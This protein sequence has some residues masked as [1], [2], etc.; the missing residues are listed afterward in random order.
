[1]T[2]ISIISACN[3]NC[4]YCF[5]Q[6]TYHKANLMLTYEEILDIFDWVADN[7][8]MGILGGEP[9]LHPDIVKILAASCRMFQE[10]ILMTNLICD[11]SIIKDIV[12]YTPTCRMLINTTTRD[13]LVDIFEENI[14]YLS[15]NLDSENDV[16]LGTTFINDEEYDLKSI[17]RLIGLG[18]KYP[19][20]KK[21]YRI[22]VATPY[23]KGKI[24]LE[25]FEKPIME[26]CARAKAETPDIV[27]NFD[28]AINNCQIPV[29]CMNSLIED[30][31]VLRVRTAPC[32]P[33]IDVMADKS[34]KYCS[35]VPD[36]LMRIEH[37]R[38]FPSDTELRNY[39]SSFRSYY[40]NQY[41]KICL[42]F[43]ECNSET[44]EGLCLALTEY[45]RK[46]NAH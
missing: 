2:N 5:Q 23:H 43:K 34:V 12:K 9:T 13:E 1:M 4:K 39:F 46:Q 18:K 20:L 33:V 40:M 7:D 16:T 32:S 44:C 6:E 29:D 17:D 41:H 37:Y 14:E 42:N 10:T 36:D 24:K 21:Y 25:S 11:K 38:D 35:S 19:N 30:Y 31:K 27:I 26:F 28:C 22:S 15:M 45:L 3:N 8:K